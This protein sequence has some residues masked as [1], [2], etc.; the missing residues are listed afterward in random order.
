MSPH[1][2]TPPANHHQP[3]NPQWRPDMPVRAR[4]TYPDRSEIVNATACGY[5][6]EARLVHIS[7]PW[8]HTVLDYWIPGI[9]VTPTG[10]PSTASR[11]EHEQ[12]GRR[13]P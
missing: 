12:Q 11:A 1:P 13:R 3:V 8:Y 10:P 5:D 6:P 4:L 2:A 9:D 7:I